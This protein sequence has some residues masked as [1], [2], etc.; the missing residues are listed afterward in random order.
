MIDLMAS[1]QPSQAAEFALSDAL[2]EAL[3]TAITPQLRV[4]LRSNGVVM[5]AKIAAGA[6]LQP[7]PG[8]CVLV[9]VVGQHCW[10][11]M[12]LSTYTKDAVLAVEGSTRLELQAPM[13]AMTADRLSIKAANVDAHLGELSV[14]ARVMKFAAKQLAAWAD[15]MHARVHTLALRAE[16]RVAKV[17]RVDLV[18][19]GQ[20]QVKADEFARFQGAQVQVVAQHNILLD[21]KRVVVN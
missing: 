18:H 9:A 17:D 20:I 11:L 14:S 12:V 2:Y 7:G 10:L 19:A 6:L 15:F 3:V 1:P 16:N 4:C 13:I 8:D 21:G 5:P